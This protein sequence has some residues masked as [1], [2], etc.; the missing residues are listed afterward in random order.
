M[1]A[2]GGLGV[3]AMA[4]SL[5]LAQTRRNPPSGRCG[6]VFG[7]AKAVSCAR[8][9][10]ARFA[11]GGLRWA[12]RCQSDLRQCYAHLIRPTLAN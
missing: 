3:L 12:G 9:F 1:S 4:Q 2:Q 6:K 10:G 11:E 5:F 7:E 8:C